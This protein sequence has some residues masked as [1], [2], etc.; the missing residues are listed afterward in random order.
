MSRT[1]VAL[2]ALFML[3]L[4]PS[5]APAAVR[6]AAPGGAV[7]GTCTPAAPCRIDRAVNMTLTTPGDEVVLAPGTYDL[8]SQA[9]PIVGERLDVHGQEG[10][11]RPVIVE[12]GPG[13]AFT[14][15]VGADG[16]TLRDVEIRSED[17]GGVALAVH[18]GDVTVQDV[19]VKSEA[20]CV[21]ASNPGQTWEDVTA[22]VTAPYGGAC[23]D[24][25]GVTDGTLRRVDVDAGEMTSGGVG[26]SAGF[27][28]LIED[29]T[30]RAG[31]QGVALM[32]GGGL[33]GNG[34]VRR[35]VAEGGV[36]G[37]SASY[38]VLITDTVA[39]ASAMYGTAL[40]HVFS[41]GN[42]M[43]LRNVTAVATGDLS[44]GVWSLMGQAGNA[45]GDI[46]A[47]NVIARGELADIDT[48][49]PDGV[50]NICALPPC[51][52]GSVDV[53]YSGFRA[54]AG[55]G[56]KTIGADNRSGDPR[57]VGGSLRLAD[58][59]PLIDAGT[60]SLLGPR[61]VDGAARVQ[62][63]A[64]DIGAYERAAPP[65][66]APADPEPAGAPA[67]A[68]EV[69]LP[70]PPPVVAADTTAPVLSGLRVRR[71]GRRLT[72]S[73]SASEAGSVRLAVRR[74]GRRVKRTTFAVT[75][76][77]NRVR[78]RLPRV[79]RGRHAVVLVATDAAGN[80][81]AARRARFRVRR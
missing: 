68:E 4:L 62:G 71:R 27:A 10:A 58:D 61:A 13:T 24:L 18:A 79:R 38:E 22:E 21:Y 72:V 69:P 41:L 39:T 31:G 56:V 55:A 67:P 73:F 37:I 64:V 25:L 81:A 66:P 28:P 17:P 54:V 53:A 57:F 15:A 63:R 32:L 5:A 35:V 2:F 11:P 19:A 12:T 34:V 48:Q 47:R 43:R 30:I 51:P 7:V 26:L 78:V 6:H 52:P 14:V 16:T 80:V 77:A 45:P 8:T 20:K 3:A 29:S 40:Y 75:P 46:E 74:G 42:G 9:N 36:A 49:A 65:E 23:M 76:G 1:F 44:R 70:P 60:A 33:T 50:A 59:S